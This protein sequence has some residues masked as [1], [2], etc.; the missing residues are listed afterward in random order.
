MIKR[1]F[2]LLLAAAVLLG[3][4]LYS[5]REQ[6]RDFVSGFIE[7]DEIRVGS[8]VGGRIISVKVQEG[9]T[10]RAGQILVA[11]DPYDLPARQ[12]EAQAQ[13]AARQASLA[14]LTAGFRAEEVGQARS[15]RDQLAAN[16]EKLQTGA[17]PQE[18]REAQAQLDQAQSQLDLGQSDF[19]R[20]KSLY[21]QGVSAA[22]EMD[23]ARNQLQVARANVKTRREA[24]NLIQEGPRIEDINQARARL[25]EGEQ[26]LRL[27]QNGYR[28]EEIDEARAAVE[29]SSATLQVIRQ[30][31]TELAIHAPV[32]GQVE[33]LD[34]QPGDLAPANAPVISLMDTSNLWVRAFVPE[35][36][37]DLA[38]DKP[39]R[40]TV[41][42]FPDRQFR[43]H[44]SFIARQ[45]EFTPRNVQT[46]EERSKQVFRIKATL[47]EGKDVLRP[48][49]AADVW[50]K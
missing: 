12:R 33:A 4:L 39:V 48:G 17:R 37:L 9:D 28:V 46:P 31:M 13:L 34:V 44:I 19:N 5:K 6:H 49:M 40:V 30:Q 20:I 24:L 26:A 11:L 23:R 35:N 3:L 18:I 7:A 36:R 2:I 25:E 22:S 47:D 50:L 32:D 45:A 1:L 38:V 14:R 15:Q 41:D 16:L 21:D 8:R 42:S 10:V 29:A 43:A 27:R